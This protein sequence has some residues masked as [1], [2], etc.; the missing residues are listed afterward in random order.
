MTS[1]L[2]FPRNTTKRAE[3][4]T[5]SKRFTFVLVVSTCASLGALE[6]GRHA[7]EQRIQSGCE[8]DVFAGCSLV[9][10][11]AIC[12]RGMEDAQRVFNKLPSH[13]VFW[14]AIYTWRMCHAW[15]W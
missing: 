13:D 14:N 12:G 11:Y 8:A 9:D 15:T 4:T 2:S 1:W 7:H 10:M 3:V 6:E 5:H